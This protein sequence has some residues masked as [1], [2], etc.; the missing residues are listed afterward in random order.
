M[1]Q[2]FKIDGMHCNGCVARVTKALAPLA[3]EVNVTLEPGR[4]TLDAPDAVSLEEVRA[5]VAK[6]GS[7]QVS[8]L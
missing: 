4:I 2:S 6:A 7:Y 8:A 5:A 3:D 1:Q